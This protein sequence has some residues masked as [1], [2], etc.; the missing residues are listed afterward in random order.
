MSS[1]LISKSP[2]KPCWM[3]GTLLM[4]GCLIVAGCRSMTGLPPSAAAVL[5]HGP[6]NQMVLHSGD[7]LKI[8]FPGAPNLDTSTG[9]RLD[10]KIT[11]PTIGEVAAA[12]LTPS[13]LQT[14]ILQVAGPQLV[15]KEVSVSVLSATFE[16]YLEG[17]VLRP[18]RLVADRVLTPLEALCEGG[19][20]FQKANLKSVYVIRRSPNGQTL[21]FK[22]NVQNAL[23]GRPSE[24]FELRPYDV[25]YVPERFTWF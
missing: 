6:T 1:D 17:A 19:I 9:V 25:I 4:V 7:T 24:H 14:E 8:N 21:N 15:V 18:G 5:A 3:W 2:K 13:E 23:D 22:M 12:G 11:L 20:D 16:V 10:G